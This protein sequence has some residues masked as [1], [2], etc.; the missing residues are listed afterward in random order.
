METKTIN[1]TGS[2][3]HHKFHLTVSETFVGDGSENYSNLQGVLKLDATSYNWSGWGSNI[4]Y[5]INING[6]TFS[7]NIPTIPKN[8]AY[9]IATVNVNN[10]EHNSDGTKNISISFSITDN[11]NQSYTSGNASAS[12]T[13][14]LTEIA[15]FPILS[16][17]SV[18][19]TLNT[20]TCSLS[21]TRPGTMTQY[22][23][24]KVSDGSIVASGSCNGDFSFTLTGLSP[25]TNYSGVYKVRAYANGG[26]GDWLTLTGSMT[27]ATL[28]TVSATGSV[29]IESA[30]RIQFSNLNYI[31]KW[32]FN[33]KA[34]VDNVSILTGNNI[35]TNNYDV[36]LTEAQKSSLLRKYTGTTKP[37]VYWEI[38]VVSNGYSYRVYT[39]GGANPT[40]EY[41][42]P[43]TATYKPTFDT[44]YVINVANSKNTDISG[45]NKYIK[46]HNKLTG[47]IKPM[48]GKYGTTGKTY[49]I[50][51]GTKST[52]L[53]YSTSNQTFTLEDVDGSSISI[54]AVDNRGKATSISIAITLIDY[55]NPTITDF[56]MTRQ[57]GVGTYGI[58]NA[59]GKYT[60]WSGLTLAN[61]IQVVKY[62]SKQRGTSTWSAWKTDI[63]LSSNSGGNWSFVNAIL[64]TQFNNTLSYDI[65]LY[66]KDR[67]EEKTLQTTLSTADVFLWRDLAHKRLGI[68]KKPEYALDVD[69]DVSY[70]GRM[71]SPVKTSSSACKIRLLPKTSYS[72][73]GTSGSDLNVYFQALLKWI[74]QTYPNDTYTT[75]IGQAEPGAQGTCVVHIYNTSDVDSTTKLPR[76][77]SGEYFQSSNGWIFTSWNYAFNLYQLARTTDL[78][79]NVAHTNVNNNFTTGQTISG[80]VNASNGYLISQYSGKQIQIGSQN[81]SFCHYITTADQH[82]FNK[83]VYVQGNIYGG[84]NYDRRLMY[85]DEITSGSN[86]NGSY[87]RL[88]NG[89][90]LCWHNVNVSL[91]S[92]TTSI[93]SSGNVYYVD[94]SWTFPVAFTSKPVVQVTASDRDSGVFGADVNDS[95]DN[96]ITTTKC[97]ATAYGPAKNRATGLQLFAIGKWK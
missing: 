41:T 49:T 43:D 82:W 46:L 21:N 18:S 95:G 14:D 8:Q 54:T 4:K 15:R 69:G 38:S 44:S 71:F 85:L 74:C 16:F 94:Y 11:A 24:A 47:T 29:G 19:K 90:Q 55:S 23:V 7:G 77:A 39:T 92:A 89:T 52:N 27:T 45:T 32:G 2:K 81:S 22:Q 80:S 28:P 58:L 60:N 25:N 35:T 78:P 50:S 34:N 87:V 3:G 84:S 76:Y 36:T 61:S 62:R 88:P 53:N 75:Y 17:N 93:N 97:L 65:E 37:K 48:V 1:A 56:D 83:S 30:S 51:C 91:G 66:I 13:M 64:S 26:W 68:N 79:T 9:T 20:M 12:G 67:L 59:K 57:G 70:S 42:I 96:V 63:S 73:L 72:T 40:T 86:S 6:T 5:S 10:V 33:C 31:E